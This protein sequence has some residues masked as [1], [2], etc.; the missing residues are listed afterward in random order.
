[1]PQETSLAKLAPEKDVRAIR[2]TMGR[3][4]LKLDEAQESRKVTP[5]GNIGPRFAPAGQSTQM[6]VGADAA[7][8]QTNLTTTP[9]ST[10][11]TSS[12]GSIILRS[13]RS[14]M[15]AAHFL[16]WRRRWCASIGSIKPTG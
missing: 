5:K 8:D 6:I 3:L 2:R 15:Q 1:M 9:I 12:S 10:A 4:R 7:N 16:C 11:P 14:P 13:A